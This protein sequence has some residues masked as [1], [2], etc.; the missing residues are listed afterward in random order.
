M[1]F[2]GRGE[3]I[4]PLSKDG[5]MVSKIQ[6]QI[7]HPFGQATVAFWPQDLIRLPMPPGLGVFPASCFSVCG[8]QGS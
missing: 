4:C 1:Q 8:K 5:W 2:P 3:T 6:L 7:M